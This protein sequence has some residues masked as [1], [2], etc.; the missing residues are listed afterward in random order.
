MVPVKNLNGRFPP[1]QRAQLLQLETAWG[2]QPRPRDRYLFINTLSA[3]EYKFARLSSR[4]F[5]D[6][7]E[8]GASTIRTKWLN[9][10]DNN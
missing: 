5:G 10:Q 1:L 4:I 7:C 6:G 9:E 2:F 8:L 3:L